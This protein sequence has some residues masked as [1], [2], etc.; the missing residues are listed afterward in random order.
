V[1]FI[2]NS[3]LSGGIHSGFLNGPWAINPLPMA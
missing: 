1:Q 2:S 3:I